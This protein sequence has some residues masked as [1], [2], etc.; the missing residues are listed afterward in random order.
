[1]FGAI[2]IVRSSDTKVY[3]SHEITFHRVGSW[4]FGKDFAK[5]VLIFGVGNSFSSQTDNCKNNFLVLR[6]GDTFGIN[7]SFGA[8]EKQSVLI[9][10][11]Q[12]K[13]LL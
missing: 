8:S 11:K 10:V 13:I 9:L 4:D 1:M 6:G 2:N 7:G 3:S 5:N 12:S